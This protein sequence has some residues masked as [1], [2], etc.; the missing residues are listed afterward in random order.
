M[1][2]V[3]PLP[4]PGEVGGAGCFKHPGRFPGGEI[5]LP[6]CR[7]RLSGGQQGEQCRGLS[8]GSVLIEPQ[9]MLRKC[10][11]SRKWFARSVWRWG[12]R[13]VLGVAGSHVSHALVVERHIS[14][15]I[16]RYT[17][18]ELHISLGAHLGKLL[19]ARAAPAR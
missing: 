17:E 4:G 14:V 10:K 18:C 12:G 16:F 13:Q 15:Y 9:E 5:L 6:V 2:H 3:G 7:L 1:A 8:L 11:V 19:A